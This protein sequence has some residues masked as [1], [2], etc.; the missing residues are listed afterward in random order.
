LYDIAEEIG[1]AFGSE[2]A[3][4]EDLTMARRGTG[5]HIIWYPEGAMPRIFGPPLARR[6]TGHLP[7]VR[8][9]LQARKL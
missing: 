8:R 6:F 2:D 1:A 5:V 9:C 4:Y 3:Y 7:S